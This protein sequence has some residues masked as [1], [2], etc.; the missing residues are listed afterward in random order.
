MKATPKHLLL[1]VEVFI[2]IGILSGFISLVGYTL[3][4]GAP[5]RLAQAALGQGSSAA[6]GAG[7]R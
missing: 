4:R 2:L 7:S 5:I 6:L 1:V 3:D